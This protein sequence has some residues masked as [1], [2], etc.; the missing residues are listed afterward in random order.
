MLDKVLRQLAR[1]PAAKR[2]AAY[3]GATCVALYTV[4]VNL[5]TISYS[6]SNGLRELGTTNNLESYIEHGPHTSKYNNALQCQ[7]RVATPPSLDAF[8]SPLVIFSLSDADLGHLFGLSEI[9]HAAPSV[10][11]WIRRSLYM[12]RSLWCH[13]WPKSVLESFGQA[14]EK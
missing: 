5:H 8:S 6:Y 2:C 9:C 4:N 7:V 13:N 1:H 10:Q 3:V 14:R 11:T 12:D